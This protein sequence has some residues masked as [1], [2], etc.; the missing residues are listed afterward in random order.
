MNWPLATN[1]YSFWDRL[2]VAGWL[3][4]T[5]RYTMGKKV[6]EFEDKMSEFSGMHAVATSS[7][8]T[9]I[10]LLF[11]VWKSKHPDQHPVVIVPAVTWA[12]SVSA[13]IAAGFEVEF[14]DVTRT[15]FSFDINALEAIL[16]RRSRVD[17]SRRQMMISNCIIWPTA[18]MGFTPN[19]RLLHGL[20]ER[21]H[22]ELFLDACEATFGWETADNRSILA[23]ASMTVTSCY[24]AHQ[25]IAVEFG[26]LFLR[27]SE[28]ANYARI[29]RNHG[30]S[31]SLPAGN[32]YR[33]ML[34]SDNPHIDPSF[35]F[36]KPGLNV[37]PV[38]VNAVFG[39]IDFAKRKKTRHHAQEVWWHFRDLLDRDRFYL[40]PYCASHIPFCLPIFVRNERQVRPYKDALNHMGIETRPIV[41]GCLTLHPAFHEYRYAGDFPEAKWIH[42]HGFYVGIPRNLSITNL[43]R[44]LAKLN[45]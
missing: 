29:I 32:G 25:I 12:T 36:V 26:F 11:E 1:P 20:A 19:M 28:D 6:A 9:A 37:R 14:C 43:N 35:L 18:L 30:L 10:Q 13:A 23:S 39:L 8:T 17:L 42:E 4:S 3:L 16:R 41:G 31:R 45:E 40:P 38:E 7:G 33:Q 27:N 22:T 21:Y 24:F 34:E 44:L 5:D 15:D 2:K